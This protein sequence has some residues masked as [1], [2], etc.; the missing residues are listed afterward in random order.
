[1]KNKLVYLLALLLF[2]DLFLLYACDACNLRQP[3]VIRGITHG[4]G[5]ESNWDWFI[6]AIILLITLLTLFYS[7]KFLI[8]PQ[9][10]NKSHIKYTIISD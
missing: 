8:K 5:P 10:K 1:M 7:L 9:E 6:V 2:K 4:S 3:K